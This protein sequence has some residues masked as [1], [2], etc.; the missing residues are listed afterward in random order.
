MRDKARWRQILSLVLLIGFLLSGGA[1]ARDRKQKKDD[2]KAMDPNKGDIL[3]AGLVYSPE[4]GGGNNSL[5]EGMSAVAGARV[6]LEGTGYETVTDGNGMFV[7][8]AGPDGP[9]KIV[10]SK[11]GYKTEMRTS[12]SGWRGCCCGT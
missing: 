7:F 11:E 10:I 5:G 9:V 8:T 6:V 3:L 1:A 4:S 12:S 2:P